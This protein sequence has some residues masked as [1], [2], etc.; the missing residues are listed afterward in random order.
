M[1]K[2]GRKG[3]PLG[4]D[5]FQTLITGNGYFVD[6]S[7]FIKEVIQDFSAVKLIT[8]PRRFGK[9]LNLS[10]LKYFFEISELDTSILFKD[11]AIWQAGEEYQKEQ[12]QY[13]VIYLTLK[14]IKKNTM[15]DCWESLMIKIAEE[16]RRHAYLLD[17]NKD[18]S[19]IDIK[20]FYGI[21][22]RSAGNMDYENALAFLSRLLCQYH[23]KPVVILIDE[24]DT[25]IHHAYTRGFFHEMIDCMKGFLGAGLKG[26][27][28]LKM[29]VITGIYQVAKESIF[30]DMNNLY[31]CSV[32]TNAFADCFGFVESE[33]ENFLLYYGLGSS[34]D[35]VKDWYNGYVFGDNTVIYNPWSILH[36]AKDKYLQPYWVNT[37]SN[38]LIMDILQKTDAIVKQKITCLMEGRGVAG[39]TINTSMN[40]RHIMGARIMNETALWNFL[41]V[42]GHLKPVN[43]HLTKE[44]H[45]ICEALIPN[46]EIT[47]MYRDMIDQWFQP[48]G[49]S[50]NM[51]SMILTD[52]AHGRLKEFE[53]HFKYLVRKTFSSF[54]VGHNA[55]ENFYH[56][57]ILGLLVHRNDTYR[58]LSNRES[59]DGRPD[60]M[61]IPT[62]KAKRGVV[63]EFKL[64]EN[65]EEDSLK[66]AAKEA[67]QQIEEKSYV[68]EFV[69]AGSSE[70]IK[71]GI[72][73][74][75]KKVAIEYQKHAT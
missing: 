57:F 40:F 59:G 62:D 29:G 61:I 72:A 49:V 27:P 15:M 19:D 2:Q 68:D 56:A 71:I 66:K 32:T 75:G 11:L 55:A 37:S 39:V 18:V 41:M 5:D 22:S 9:T 51:L 58:V 42:S 46:K 20:D 35:E 65:K 16:Y 47:V 44:G 21:L 36:F 54:D 4:V 3:I 24:Y 31:I 63:I 50:S 73:F 17:Q 8:R 30:S 60:V 12:G 43:M 38:E 14:D 74:A 70:V 25:P 64:A 53:I 33:V 48:E 67:I 34:F 52:L 7:L 23:K 28:Y 1:D 26:N 6:K 69:L 10:M 45:R 13:P